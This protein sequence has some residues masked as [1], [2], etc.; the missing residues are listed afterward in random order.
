MSGRT[1]ATFRSKLIIYA[2]IGLQKGWRSFYWVST[3]PPILIILIFKMYITRSFNHAF[4]FYVPTNQEL[5]DAQIHSQRADSTGNRLQRR[6]GHPALHQEL[7]TPM[8]HANMTA[9]LPDVYKG[10]IGNTSTK[11]D[12]TKVDAAVVAGI[13]IAAVEQ[14]GS[15]DTPAR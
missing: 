1:T 7:F 10:K 8:V 13:T 3:I 12:G 14:V 6:F 4:N 2:A 15:V 9:L 5:L 11:L